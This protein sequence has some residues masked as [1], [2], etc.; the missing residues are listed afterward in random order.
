MCYWNFETVV[1]HTIRGRTLHKLNSTKFNLIKIYTKN[2]NFHENS[3]KTQISPNKHSYL[4]KLAIIKWCKPYY[5]KIFL[6]SLNA[7][8][9]L[10]L[11][12]LP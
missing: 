1:N 2:L 12:S 3:T 4:N 9:S 5:V 8:A 6:N 7:I 10:S 11:C